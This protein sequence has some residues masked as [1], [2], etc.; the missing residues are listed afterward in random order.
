LTHNKK[1]NKLS[2]VPK[3]RGRP[4]EGRI[5]FNTYLKPEVKKIIDQKAQKE[6]ISRGK[7]IEKKFQ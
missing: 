7:V 5:P 1:H 6:K 3:R 4:S 2:I